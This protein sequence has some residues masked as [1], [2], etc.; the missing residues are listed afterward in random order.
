MWFKRVEQYYMKF[1]VLKYAKVLSLCVP[2][3]MFI[4]NSSLKV[5]NLTSIVTCGSNE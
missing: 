4:R 3:T 2:K 5:M 1:M